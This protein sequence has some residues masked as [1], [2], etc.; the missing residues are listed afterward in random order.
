M[1]WKENM[2]K[3]EFEKA[4]QSAEDTIRTDYVKKL[5]ALESKLP[6]QKTEKEL[7]LEQKEKELLAKEREYKI[8]DMLEINQ[9]PTGLS[10]YISAED[11]DVAGQEI[12][13][14]L[15]EYLL[16]NSHKP[17]KHN[18][19]GDTVTKD[20][21]KSMNYSERLK[22]EQTNPELYKKLSN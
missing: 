12:S 6:T 16:N 13:T 22:L 21:F 17:T 14:I 15:N 11:I 1:E 20:Q 10:K 8:K 19:G 9:L 4:I 3:E 5:K 18:N 7:A 2:T